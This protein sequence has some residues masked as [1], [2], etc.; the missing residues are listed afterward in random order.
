MNR[1]SYIYRFL[2]KCE[3][4]SENSQFWLFMSTVYN[5]CL[6]MIGRL[7]IAFECR[8][9][10]T[11]VLV[12]PFS[13]GDA[14]L[15]YRSFAELESTNSVDEPIVL[16]APTLA[17]VLTKL[18]LK[19][20]RAI[21]P[22]RIMAISKAL[23]FTPD[24]FPNVVLSQPWHFLDIQH[25]NAETH[26][27]SLPYTL[28][29]ETRKKLF[30][31]P[32]MQNR[33]IILSP[34]EQTYLSIGEPRLPMSFW[35]DLAEEL[36]RRGYVVFTNCDGERET[37]IRNTRVFFPPLTELSGALD[38]AGNCISVRSGFT[39][40]ASSTQTAK[41]VVLYPSENFHALYRM[42][43]MW[44]KMNVIEIIYDLSKL[45]EL[46]QKLIDSFSDTEYYEN[47]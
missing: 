25:L 38:Y 18:G 43:V 11:Y 33:C 14:L 36:T 2:K 24:R 1:N 3:T 16:S 29:A 4:P 40:W 31:E 28:S 23:L 19:N 6:L 20:N 12:A 45:Q 46:H 9:S 35:E 39:D 5:I 27:Q 21:P 10:S 44:E 41:M 8:K 47:A 22:W 15:L 30:P 7:L 13:M 42:D 26:L 34:Y 17:S 32:D 37:A